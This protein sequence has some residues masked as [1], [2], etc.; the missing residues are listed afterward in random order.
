[1]T[2][3]EFHSICKSLD[4]ERGMGGQTQLARMLGWHYG[5][6]WRKLNGKSRITQ[7][8]EL[9]IRQAISS[10]KASGGQIPCQAEC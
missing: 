2:P 4:D 6:L 10:L 8:D 9:A 3:A 5:T 1:M 7:S